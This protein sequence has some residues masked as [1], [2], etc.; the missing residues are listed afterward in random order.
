[1]VIGKNLIEILNLLALMSVVI[2]PFLKTWKLAYAA[3]SMIVCQV[4]ISILLVYQVFSIGIIKYSYAGSFITGNIPIQIDYLSAWFIL[5]ISFT[6]LTGAWYGVHYMKKYQEQT[7]NLVLH[8]IAFILAYTALIDI[9]M[10][11]NAL[12]FLVVWEIMALSAFTLVIFEHYKKET[13]RAGINFLIQSHI[14]I[15]F[16]TVAFF[17]AKVATGSFDFSAISTYTALHPRLGFG[18]FALF[19]IGFSIKAGFVPFHTWLPLAHPAAPSHISG[20]MSGVIIKIGIFGILRM[21]DLVNGYFTFIGIFIIII[22]VITGL[23]GVMMA[24]VQNNL[25]RL[26]AYSSIENIGIIGLGIGLGCLGKGINQQLLLVAGFGGALLHVLNHSLFKSLLFFN[27]GNIYQA[28][29]SLNIDSLGG[30]LKKI[31]KTA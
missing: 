24:I 23:Y 27:A 15:L 3:L 13:L 11:Q 29:H 21:L 17:W 10:V 8:A 22:S 25:K 18:L 19:F 9:C 14:S 31:P 20:I 6:F 30:L 1:M 7:G 5:I 12:V 26:L 28:T 2:F 16:L 4:L